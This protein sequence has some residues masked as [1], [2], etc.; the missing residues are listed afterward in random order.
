MHDPRL[1]QLHPDDNVGTAIRGLPA[2][3][4]LLLESG[5]VVVPHAIGLGHKVALR[6]LRR[7]ERVIKYGAPIGS[8]T[9]EIAAG[10]HVHLHNLR[11]DYLPTHERGDV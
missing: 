10:E 2:G 5:S 11:S 9:G 3:T 4:T 1:L 7:G 6:P 8:A